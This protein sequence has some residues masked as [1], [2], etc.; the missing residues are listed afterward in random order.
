MS[1]K[2]SIPLQMFLLLLALA[3][4]WGGAFTLIKVL[5]DTLT[6]VEMAA[7][8][9]ALGASAVAIFLVA[10][11]ELGIP[12]ASMI[13]PIGVVALFDTLIPYTLVGWAQTR[14][15]SG[16]AAVLIAAMPLFTVMLAAGI[17]RQ[18]RIT[19]A[20]LLGLAIGFAGVM[21]MMGDPAA[22]GESDSLA[23]VAVLGAAASYAVGAL[24]ARTLL[25]RVD[26]ANFTFVKLGI[27][28]LLAA[29]ATFAIGDGAGFT[30]MNGGDI[31]ALLI[32]GIVCTGATFVLYFRVVAGIGSIGA[33]TVT[34]MIPAFALVFGAAFLDEQV[35]PA[36]IAGMALIIAGVAAVMF[37]PAVEAAARRL[38]RRGAPASTAVPLAP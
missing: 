1:T 15:D 20:R 2:T 29:A 24:Y 13:G 17:L 34:Y 26:P 32:L 33:S 38:R 37:G 12:R 9:L 31:A 7:G 27:G 23:Q 22:F 5:I 6:A 16:T 4:M 36:T 28:A 11:R 21:V 14:I 25:G 8:R 19:P 35:K 10:R 30:E 3:A 18:E